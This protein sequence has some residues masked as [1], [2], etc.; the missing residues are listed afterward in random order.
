MNN[1]DFIYMDNL[2]RI[3][4]SE[5]LDVNARLGSVDMNADA[6]QQQN[7]LKMSHLLPFPYMRLKNVVNVLFYETNKI[8]CWF[9]TLNCLVL[10]LA[11]LVVFIDLVASLIT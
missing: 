10:T 8:T 5:S 11:D 4:L 9:I 3:L 6:S 1:N 2:R 7:S